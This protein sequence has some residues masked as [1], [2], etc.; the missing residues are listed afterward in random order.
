VDALRNA[1]GVLVKVIFEISALEDSHI[2]TACG[3]GLDVNADFCEDIQQALAQA[4]Q[5]R[6]R[7]A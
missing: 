3:Y 7:L 2:K 1:S 6:R 5:H 4:E